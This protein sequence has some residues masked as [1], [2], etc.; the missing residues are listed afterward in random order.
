MKAFL[1]FAISQ[2]LIQALA[3]ASVQPSSDEIIARLE[4]EN[5]R[6]RI[7]LKEYSGSRQYTMKNLRFG[8]QAEVAVFINY[9]QV[10]GERYTVTNRSGS[11]VLNGIIDKVLASQ[12]DA[13]L[14]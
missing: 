6:R 10:E 9:R 2:A 12:A 4:S 1:V 11:E 8:K 7:L 14:S 3:A 13:S 5:N